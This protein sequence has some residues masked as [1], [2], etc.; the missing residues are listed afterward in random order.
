MLV[1]MLR[2]HLRP[3]VHLIAAVLLLQLVQ[4]LATLYL[5]TLNAD[6]INND[7]VKGDTGYILHTGV[8][9]RAVTLVQI[10]CAVAAVYFGAYSRPYAAQFAQPA[11]EVDALSP[12]R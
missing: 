1:R 12:L 6:I 8:L 5:P 10:V 7:V 11:A 3:Y 4:T 2:R 9:M